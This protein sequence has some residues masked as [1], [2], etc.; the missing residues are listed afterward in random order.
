MY[1]SQFSN[2]QSP[3]NFSGQTVSSQY[4][5]YQK[6]FQPTGYVNSVYGQN[7]TVSSFKTSS[8]PTGITSSQS[9]NQYGGNF[10]SPQS[11]HTANYRGDQPGHD[12]YLRADATNPSQSGYGTGIGMNMNTSNYS[13]ASTFGGSQFQNQGQSQYQ[14]Q[15]VSPQSY[16]TA[17]YRGNQQGHDNYLRAD[18][19]NPS[20]S[21][22]NAGTGISTYG[23]SSF[24]GSQFSN[25]SGQSVS[26]FV[27]PQ[28]YH[29]AN[30]RGNQQGHD[31]YLR[32]DS[33]NPSQS[34]FGTGMGSSS[35][36]GSYG[37]SSNRNF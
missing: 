10:A 15:F 16:H 22:F 23:A 7:N 29:T 6:P 1:Q 12:N 19:T 13:T 3:S 37:F 8:I 2:N 5:G 11:F 17:N 9:Y 25:T 21:G 36:S 30:Y 34:Q 24:G 35:M 4:R 14:N 20:Q 32:A 27:N 26:G 28:S 18:S 33:G 31:N